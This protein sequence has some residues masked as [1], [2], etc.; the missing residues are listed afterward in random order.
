[1]NLC[2]YSKDIHRTKCQALTITR[3]THSPLTT[4]IAR[5]RRHTMLSTICN[6]VFKCQD[7]QHTICVRGLRWCRGKLCRVRMNSVQVSLA[8][9]AEA[10]TRSNTCLQQGAVGTTLPSCAFTLSPLVL[11][12][13]IIYT[14]RPQ[15]PDPALL[16]TPN[17][18]EGMRP[19]ST[20][21]WMVQVP[22]QFLALV[23][24]PNVTQPSCAQRHTSIKVRGSGS[25][26]S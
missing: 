23:Q 22:P 17:W 24:F 9:S 19:S 18:P 16:A 8:P 7:V 6:N 12:E 13:H 11:P 26:S 3:L 1:M 20:V 25:S 4:K 2:Q 15:F 10:I 5:T 14:V 21:S